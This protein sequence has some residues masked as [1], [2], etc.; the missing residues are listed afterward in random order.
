MHERLQAFRFSAHP[1]L[2]LLYLVPEESTSRTYSMFKALRIS[3][4][5]TFQ[6]ILYTLPRSQI[7]NPCCGSS[8]VLSSLSLSLSSDLN[9]CSSEFFVGVI[10]FSHM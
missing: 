6:K 3:C 9:Y 4:M 1:A 8:S 7:R 10:Q 5:Y 2:L